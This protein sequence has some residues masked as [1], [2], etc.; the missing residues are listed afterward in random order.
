MQGPEGRRALVFGSTGLVGARLVQALV[1]DNDVGRIVAPVRRPLLLPWPSMVEA[2]VVS[3]DDLETALGSIAVD[4]VFLC[5][6]TT[7]RKAG[8]REAFRRVDLHLTV[9]AARVAR[10]LGAEDAF[11]VSSVGADPAGRSFYLR[12]KGEAEDALGEL[13]FRSVH[14]FRP[15]IL[16]GPRVESRP[17]ERVGIRLG[18]LLAPLMVGPLRRYRPVSA[19]AVAR[20]MAT[21]ASH[22]TEGRHVHESEA[23]ARMVAG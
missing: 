5:L 18:S 16:T 17:A 4:Q 13:S 11:L 20:A 23:I 2:P 12:V 15:S 10:S 19:R 21:T 7:M 1:D 8:S 6:G 3:F 9:A 14:V 22:P